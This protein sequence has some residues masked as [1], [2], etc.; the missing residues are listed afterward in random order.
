MKRINFSLLR[1]ILFLL[2]TF[3]TITFTELRPIA[4]MEVDSY[5]LPMISIQYRG[6][7]VCTQEDIEQAKKD[8]PTI[9][10]GVNCYDD[11][12]SSKLNIIDENHWYTYYFPIYAIICMPMKLLLQLIMVD[13]SKCFAI[14][15]G[16]LLLLTLYLYFKEEDEDAQPYKKYFVC[17]LII[18][19]PIWFNIHYIGIEPVAYSLI[20]LAMLFWRKQKYKLSAFIVSVVCMANPAIMGLGIAIFIDYIIKLLSEGKE[21]FSKKS[22]IK[23]VEL[24]AC[25][26]P[27]LIPFIVNYYYFGKLYTAIATGGVEDSIFD[28]SL[29]YMFDLNLGI[30]SFAPI[31]MILFW[32]SVVWSIR[33]RKRQLFMQ[34]LAYIFMVVICSNMIHINSGMI[35]CARYQMWMYPVLAI[36]VYDFLSICAKKRTKLQ[37]GIAIGTLMVSCLFMSY[38]LVYPYT[39]MSKISKKILDI[40]PSAYI[41]ICDSTF[42]SRVNHIDGGYN[43]QGIA[44]YSDSVTGEIRKIQYRNTDEVKRELLSIIKNCDDTINDVTWIEKNLKATDGKVH[45][46]NIGRNNRE[47]FRELTDEEKKLSEDIGVF[48]YELGT[49]LSFDVNDPTANMYCVTGFSANEP[50]FTWTDGSYAKMRFDVADIQQDLTLQFN[51][52]NFWKK[53]DVLIYADDNYIGK[54]AVDENDIYSINIPQCFVEDGSVVIKFELPDAESPMNVSET[55]DSRLLAIGFENI[56][57]FESIQD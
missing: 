34:A 5:V 33:N 49:L 17:F 23:V 18:I 45:Y 24:C 47:Q 29:A 48:N 32:I 28:R 19:S 1:K 4:S 38:N 20:F 46:I 14:T 2:F 8:F 42:N 11:L 54:V 44:I 16:L 52:F 53:Q 56:V 13:Q 9:Y 22:M 39:E 36:T 15:A 27:S 25:Y 6:S 40:S 43:P 31:L 7:L 21:L 37:Y 50:G 51:G 35:Y 10:E 3:V 30:S 41:S 26:L 57:L 55:T 12:R